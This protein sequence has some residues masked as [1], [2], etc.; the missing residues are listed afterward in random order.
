MREA[1]IRALEEAKWAAKRAKL[2]PKKRS[3]TSYAKS[4]SFCAFT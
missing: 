1:E 4:K 2:R 3:E